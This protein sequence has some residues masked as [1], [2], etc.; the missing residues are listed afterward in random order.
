MNEAD[1]AER[2]A[3]PTPAP[4]GGAAAARVGLLSSS[5]LR[6]VIGITLKKVEGD[7]VAAELKE[8]A[9][10][11]SE[12]ADR[13]R[14]LEGEDSAAFEAFMEAARLPRGTEEEK[15]RRAVARREAAARATRVPLSTLET[16]VATLELAKRIRGLS[17]RTRLRA[18]SDLIAAIELSRAAFLVAELNIEANLPHLDENV[19]ADAR[20]ERES[21]RDEMEALSEE[22]RR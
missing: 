8:A 6:M 22:L 4:G 14:R 2:L 1:F 13:F 9:A 15:A 20:L 3:A 10:A 7:G 12:L 5:L 21:R 18:A 19:A 16:A 11:A 17:A